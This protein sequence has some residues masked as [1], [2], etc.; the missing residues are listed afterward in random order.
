MLLFLKHFLLLHLRVALS[1]SH[2]NE[3]EQLIILMFPFKKINFIYL[4]LAVLGL[5]AV[6]IF[7]SCSEWGL[8]SN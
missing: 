1:L 5:I 6:L 8:L 2:F 4:F 3:H 7:S